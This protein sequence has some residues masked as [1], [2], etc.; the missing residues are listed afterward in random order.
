MDLLMTDKVDKSEWHSLDRLLDYYDQYQ[1]DEEREQ[2]R[3]N[4]NKADKYK[5]LQPD[6]DDDE[7]LEYF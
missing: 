4:Q 5:H 6:F 2:A 3:K 7:G 1:S